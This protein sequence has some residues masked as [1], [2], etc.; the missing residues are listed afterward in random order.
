MSR[1]TGHAV[2]ALAA[3]DLRREPAHTAELRSQLLLGEVVRLGARR[4]GGRWV[5]VEGDD[6]YA[7]WARSWGL[8]EASASRIAGWRRRAT[9]RVSAILAEVHARPGGRGALVSPLFLNARLIAGP[10]RAGHVPVELP[11]GRRG[12]VPASALAR[13]GARPPALVD[14]VRSLLGVPYLWGG[15][16]PAAFD[17]SGFV[18]Q[19]LA[20][21]GVSVP[22]DARLQFRAAR[23]LSRGETPREGDLIF[24]AHPGERVS[25]VGIGLGGTWFAHCSGRVMINS[26]DPANPLCDKNLQEWFR[27]WRRPVR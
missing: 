8:V 17:C 15:R 22:R 21:Q 24:F 3:L 1:T 19:V 7:G 11:D 18:Q 20:E 16:T 5:R 25:H 26:S 12:Y 2:V 23:R 10:A 14:R 6:H 9:A 13:P 27:G 4:G